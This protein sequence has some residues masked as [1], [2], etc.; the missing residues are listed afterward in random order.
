MIDSSDVIDRYA[1]RFERHLSGSP[2]D[3]A[4]TT[5]EL[6]AHLSDAAE[7]GELA[8][9]LSRLGTPETAA[10][11]FTRPAPP[12]RPAPLGRRLAAEAIDVVPLIAV[13]IAMAVPE[14]A[15]GTDIRVFF[16]PF[17]GGDF[18][19]RGSSGLVGTLGVALAL[20]WSILALGIMECLTQTTPGKWLL[21]LR[22]V[23]ASG[24][25]VPLARA[26]ARRLS[27]LA[28]QFAVLDWIPALDRA[29]RQRF[30]ER[31]TRTVVISATDTTN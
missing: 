16:P 8:E 2:E 12:L 29:R 1:R 11:T 19:P 26:V 17:I 25:R 5:A 13:T 9:A 20:V 28:G 10:A 15:K 14:F 30:L 31:L 24:L 22:T 21:G 3:R 4:R 23:T 27:Y 7:A 6:V 18:A